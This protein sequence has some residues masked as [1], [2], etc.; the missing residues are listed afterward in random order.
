MI[1]VLGNEL[2]LE[3][4]T[5]LPAIVGEGE[6]VGPEAVTPKPEKSSKVK[7][8]PETASVRCAVEIRRTRRRLGM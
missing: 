7:S 1:G 5:Q 8:V 4:S 2:D 6:P 3:G